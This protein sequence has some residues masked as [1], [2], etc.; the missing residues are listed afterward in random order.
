MEA[1]AAPGPGASLAPDEQTTTASRLGALAE[2][3]TTEAGGAIVLFAAV[4]VGLAWAN[5][6]W[7]DAYDR[8]WATKLSLS[9]GHWTLAHDLRDWVNDG[10]MTLFFLVIGLEVRREFD[11]GEFRERRRVAAPVLG[12]V[13][14]MFLPVLIFLAL[15]GGGDAARE[16]ALVIA[17]DTAFAVGVL[18]LVGSR[19]SLRLR[20]F[21][22]TLVIVDDGAAVSVIA[23]AYTSQVDFGALAAAFVLLAVM[24]Y[25]RWRGVERSTVYGA[26]ALAIWLATAESGVHPTVAGVAIG[27]LT[28]AHPPRR[29]DLERA[30][31]LTRLFRQRPSADLAVQAAR[32]ITQ[33]LSPNVR[34]QH[35]LHPWSSLLVV[36]LFALANAGLRLNGTLLA[37][38]FGSPLVIG[39]VLGL[40][41]GK[42]VGIPLGSWVSTWRW[43]GGSALAVGW[44]S[45]IAASS[46]GGIGFTMS[47]L[48]AGLSYSGPQLEQAKLGIFA[49]SILAAALSITM[50]QLVGHLPADVLHRAEA[51]TAKPVADLSL[52]VDPALDHIRDRKS[53][54]LNSSHQKISY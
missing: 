7:A 24:A 22:L 50:F 21:L 44:P 15:N 41:V 38:A 39:I 26:L 5:S 31:G 2:F 46:V 36:P 54:R 42:T 27:L 43:F 28:P 1:P 33:S 19:S 12:A 34:L 30:T 13:G 18:A 45:L 6:P 37:S 40:V 35:R 10:L 11:L 14:G 23:I 51:Q 53:T 17:T 16:W 32:R 52:P 47:L 8:L 25:L 29:A 9:L 4:V 20:S 3:L 48:I 49:A